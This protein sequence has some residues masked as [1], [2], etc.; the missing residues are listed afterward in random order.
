EYIEQSSDTEIIGP[1]VQ[2]GGGGDGGGHGSNL[3]GGSLT[4]ELCPARTTATV[5][6]TTSDGV[7]SCTVT[8]FHSLQ[9]CQ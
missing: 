8:I 5:C 9:P 2:E 3:G 1:P 4:M 7:Q 6:S